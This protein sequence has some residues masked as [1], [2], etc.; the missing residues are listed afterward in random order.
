MSGD[1]ENYLKRQR[2]SL[3]VESPDDQLIWEGIRQELQCS[4]TRA[5]KT[6][7]LIRIRNIAA[8][9]LLLISV[10]YMVQDILGE[11]R[12]G[13]EFSLADLDRSLGERE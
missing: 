2:A 10:G 8:V 12:M 13:R 3:D 7:T 1:L 11:R 9:M 6:G 4:R 5:Q